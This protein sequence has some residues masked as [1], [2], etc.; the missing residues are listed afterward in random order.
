MDKLGEWEVVGDKGYEMLY[1]REEMDEFG[2][3]MV[4]RYEEKRFK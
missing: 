2:I 4:M 1:L 3:E